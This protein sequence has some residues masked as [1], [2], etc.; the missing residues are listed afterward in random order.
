M[1]MVLSNS[2]ATLL[3]N[4]IFGA[5]IISCSASC[6]SRHSSS[7]APIAIDVP[8]HP[9]EELTK[10]T[11]LSEIDNLMD[12]IDNY[13]IKMAFQEYST[14]TFLSREEIEDRGYFIPAD[15]GYFGLYTLLNKNPKTRIIENC[16]LMVINNKTRPWTYT[17]KNDLLI[18]LDIFTNQIRILDSITVGMKKE[19]L[20][21]SMPPPI[22]QNDSSMVFQVG[23]QQYMIVLF[24]ESTVS[25]I[26]LIRTKDEYSNNNSKFFLEQNF[27][28]K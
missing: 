23:N 11:V 21:S 5:F 16:G 20:L 12:S 6:Q 4:I 3:H 15:K 1:K 18:E 26:R 19:S 27:F 22:G 10:N 28:F 25:L 14:T 7:I 24:R 9:I 2:I 8:N 17:S 13:S